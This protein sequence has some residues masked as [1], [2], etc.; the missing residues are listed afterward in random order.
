M[1]NEIQEVLRTVKYVMVTDF[2]NHWE[3]IKRS[4]FPKS[5][6]HPLILRQPLSKA[7][8]RTL[9]IKREKQKVIGCSIG[10]SSK[11]T[12]GKNGSNFT[13]IHFFVTD[14][15][16]FPIL[17]EYKN[18]KIGWHLNKMYPD[19]NDHLIPCFLAEMGETE[20][21]RLFELYCHY[22][23]KLI[24]VNSLHPFPTVRN[25][26][27]ADGEFFLGDLYVLYDATVNNNFRE[28]K[29][30]Q[31]AKYVLKVRGKRTVTIGRQQ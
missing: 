27:K 10:Y 23:L 2:K 15:Q 30:E 4:S 31:I 12:W 6:T 9:F 24:G 7:A 3:E 21:W 5:F 25:K 29:K 1:Q 28:D 17:N 22:L 19:F 16:P 26:G 14:L 8:V 11:F 18:L 20:D 13:L